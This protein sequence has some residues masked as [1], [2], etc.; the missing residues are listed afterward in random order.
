MLCCAVL[1]R[2]AV[3]CCAVSVSASASVSERCGTVR[4]GLMHVVNDKLKEKVQ[5]AKQVTLYI[6]DVF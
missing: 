2:A 4:C 3:L 5:L 1:C 6:S